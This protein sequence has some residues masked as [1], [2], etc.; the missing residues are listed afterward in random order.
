V[1]QRSKKLLCLRLDSTVDVIN[2][3][4]WEACPNAG[5]E[6]TGLEPHPCIVSLV[7]IAVF[8]THWTEPPRR[9]A[10]LSLGPCACCLRW[11]N[12]PSS[13][14]EVGGK[15][16]P[17]DGSTTLAPRARFAH[18]PSC[19]LGKITSLLLGLLLHAC[20]VPA[21]ESRSFRGCAP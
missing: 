13:P 11:R 2:Y 15:K 19:T 18:F 17:G 1:A 4:L 8:C 21:A 5:K 16:P 6:A 20:V 3:I 9:G 14:W 7:R 12:H 10:E